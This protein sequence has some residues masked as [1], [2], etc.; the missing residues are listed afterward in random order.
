MR[1]LEKLFENMEQKREQENIK[2][3]EVSN[4]I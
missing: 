1:Y 4:D 3:K 2:N